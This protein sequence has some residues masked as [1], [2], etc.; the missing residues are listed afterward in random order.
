MVPRQV[1][2][3]FLTSSTFRDKFTFNVQR[4]IY[5][6]RV[7]IQINLLL[8]KFKEEFQDKVIDKLKSDKIPD[9]AS[10]FRQENPSDSK[11]KISPDFFKISLSKLPR[12]LFKYPSQI[13]VQ[14]TVYL[15]FKLY[16]SYPSGLQKAQLNFTAQFQILVF[17]QQISKQ[18][19]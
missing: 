10:C 11:F 12:P 18:T 3:R 19:L 5:F 7:Q 15:L 8:D 17:F 13:I 6:R 2:K 9:K 14:V 1:Q 4:Q 16:L